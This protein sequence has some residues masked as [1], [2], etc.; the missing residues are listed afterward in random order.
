MCLVLFLWTGGGDETG[1]VK[2]GEGARETGVS[3]LTGDREDEMGTLLF[4]ISGNTLGS[5]TV[6][7]TMLG[8]SRELELSG[9]EMF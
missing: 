1:K 7:N 6:S 2:A 3:F 4:G 8:T 5:G 9:E